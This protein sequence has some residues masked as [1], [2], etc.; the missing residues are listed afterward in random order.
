MA[1]Q[2][3]L[4]G[5]SAP[6]RN[7]SPTTTIRLHLVLALPFRHSQPHCLPNH[8][9]SVPLVPTRI[10]RVHI[11]DQEIKRQTTKRVMRTNS[12]TFCHRICRP[13][14]FSNISRWKSVMGQMWVS[15][16]LDTSRITKTQNWKACLH[17]I[18]RLAHIH[19]TIY[20]HV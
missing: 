2:P 6:S 9:R 14:L 20:S 16:Q 12:T 13:T 3:P 5:C 19:L 4:A 18:C 10:N 11:P 17:R 1:G 15:L 8:R 7:L